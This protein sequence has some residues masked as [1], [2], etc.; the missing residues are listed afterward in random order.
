MWL[1]WSIKFLSLSS[2]SFSLMLFHQ[3]TTDQSLQNQRHNNKSVWW[4]AG[5][6]FK[7]VSD[8]TTAGQYWND[9]QSLTVFLVSSLGLGQVLQSYVLCKCPPHCCAKLGTIS[10]ALQFSWSLSL[11]RVLQS[12]VLC[13]CPPHCCAQ[14]GTISKALQFS[15][16]LSLGRV[17]L[18]QSYVLCKC[19]PHCCAS[20]LPTAVHNLEQSAKPYSLPC[21]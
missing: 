17:L 15:W 5:I 16:S 20:V 4:Y 3:Q 1:S 11:G 14:L 19:P 9:Q 6:G 21:L 18:L 10:K 7:L 8:W 2:L 13:K 12:Y